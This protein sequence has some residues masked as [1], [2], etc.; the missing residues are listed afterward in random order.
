MNELSPQERIEEQI[1]AYLDG[2][3]SADEAASVE[4]LLT[5]R[6]DLRRLHD[7]MLA[8]RARLKALYRHRLDADFSEHVLRRAERAVLSRP[9]SQAGPPADESIQKTGEASDNGAAPSVRLPRPFS[10]ARSWL[11]AGLAVAAAVVLYVNQPG[12]DE[13]QDK[14]AG[15]QRLAARSGKEAMPAQADSLEP[16]DS[17]FK[18]IAPDEALTIEQVAKPQSPLVRKTRKLATVKSP[19]AKAGGAGGRQADRF[20]EN[21]DSKKFSGEKQN[22]VQHDFLVSRQ[23]AQAGFVE[24][25]LAENKIVMKKNAPGNAK[26]VGSADGPQPRSLAGG[27]TKNARQQFDVIYVEG[28]PQQ[29]EAILSA[30]RSQPGVSQPNA[31]AAKADHTAPLADATKKAKLE[32]TFIAGRAWRDAGEARLLTKNY[33]NRPIPEAAP[34]KKADGD[35]GL[36]KGDREHEELAAGRQI[37]RD[38]LPE[39]VASKDAPALVT[40]KLVLRLVDT[41]NGKPPA[42]SAKP[43]D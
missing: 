3:L 25:L 2:E 34:Q 5:D 28:S 22:V 43:S 12:E 15:D 36:K 37:D 24:R 19:L 14:T 32:S 30:L 10:N 40:I 7:E 20:F 13:L 4:Q 11:W 16:T 31:D 41:A 42:P 21:R 9:A 17:A 33:R 26:P 27:P 29:V 39:T 23:V 8:V 35:L 1:S 18:A 38:A 6:D